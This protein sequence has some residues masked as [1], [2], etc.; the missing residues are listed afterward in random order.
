MACLFQTVESFALTLDKVLAL[1]P[2]RLSVFNYAHLPHLFKVQ[3]QMDENTL[4]SA[5]T[6]LAI[7]QYVIERLQQAGYV[8]IGMDHFAKPDDELALAQEGGTLYRN[9]QGY[10]THAGCDLIG[11]G[12]TS[13]GMVDDTY[14]QNVKTLEEY[15]ECVS[16]GKLPVY[17]GVRL[18]TDDKLRRALITQLICCFR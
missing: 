12:I 5:A 9:F 7:L 13:I 10:S 17:R 2:D 6:K 14:S 18:T 8:Y 11:L 1:N 3:K 15:H 4:P 16:T